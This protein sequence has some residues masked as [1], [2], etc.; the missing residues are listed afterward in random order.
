M[1]YLLLLILVLP[2]LASA[3]SLSYEER[4]DAANKVIK[5][6]PEYTCFQE[7]WTY[8]PQLPW[9][10]GGTRHTKPHMLIRKSDKGLIF[11]QPVPDCEK[12]NSCGYWIRS[13]TWN[14][15]FFFNSV[16]RIECPAKLNKKFIQNLLETEY[17]DEFK[18]D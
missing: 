12:G 7:N 6:F 2:N 10:I 5:S 8:K 4:K 13:F 9:E 18:L 14:E 11:A 15:G 3:K 16:E 17:K 1:K